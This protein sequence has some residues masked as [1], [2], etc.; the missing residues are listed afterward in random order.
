MLICIDPDAPLPALRAQ[1]GDWPGPHCICLSRN[2]AVSGEAID[3]ALADFIV[4]RHMTRDVSTL[5][6]LRD[7]VLRALTPGGPG[8][9]GP[10]LLVRGS[11]TAVEFDAA[12]CEA[13]AQPFILGA[14]FGA[15][16]GVLTRLLLG[17]AI[18][19]NPL[20]RTFLTNLADGLTEGHT[21]TSLDLLRTHLVPH[22]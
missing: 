12:L 18:V 19:E 5:L 13:Q 9:S 16:D 15:A 14:I 11:I 22:D 3:V 10:L 21:A 8:L 17:A 7:V 20:F 2:A 1:T 6:L 4:F